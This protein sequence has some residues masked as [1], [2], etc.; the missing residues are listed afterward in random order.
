MYDVGPYLPHQLCRKQRQQRKSDKTVDFFTEGR[1]WND[2]RTMERSDMT[3]SDDFGS[4]DLQQVPN[5]IASRA[6]GDD[7]YRLQFLLVQPSNEHREASYSPPRI[8][9]MMDEEDAH[10]MRC[11]GFGMMNFVSHATLDTR[12]RGF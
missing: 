9:G 7:N 6:I 2:G 10:S 1:A 3:L 11:Y 8:M 4:R 5:R 12:L